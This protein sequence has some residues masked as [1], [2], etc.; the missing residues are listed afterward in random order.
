MSQNQEWN[1]RS[2]LLTMSGAGTA[3]MLNPLLSWAGND[4]DPGIAGIVARTFGIDTHNHIDVPLIKSELPGPKV[5]LAG[6]LNKSG[7]KAICMTFAVDYQKLVNPGDA[8]ERFLNGLTAMDEILKSNNMQRSLNFKDLELAKKAKKPTVIQSVEGGHFLEGKIERLQITY[9]RG[10]RHLGLLH[11]NDA[12]VP[13]GD[14]FTKT[15]Q[16][17]GLTTF[18]SEVIRECERLGI[19]VDLS[20]CDNNTVNGAL[21]VAKNPVLVSH[22]GLNTRLGNNEF[23]SKMMMPRLI[24]NEQ[25]KIV[26]DNGGVIGVW[27]HLADSPTEFA[28]NIKAMVDV[29]G[30]DH[31]CIGTDTKLTPAYRSPNDKGWGQGE[32][33]KPQGQNE[34]PKK[35]NDQKAQDNNKKQG[36]QG[37]NQT[38]GI[39]KQGFYYTVVESLLNA[40]FKEGEI[41]KIGG[42]NYCRIFD[43]ATKK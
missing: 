14:I 24:N 41:A 35:E 13:L 25:A 12:S 1:R 38:W 7:L 23:M 4:L 18:G 36:S 15:P 33:K 17:G 5:D 16:W 30:I 39:E 37:T 31:V 21:K 42:G 3:L 28:D 27:T 2:F 26:A 19:L 32:D 20:H 11:D 34:P 40:G 10:L 9:D 8:Y 22:T 43:I 6:E 29:V